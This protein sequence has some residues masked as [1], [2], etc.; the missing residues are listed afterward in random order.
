M[1]GFEPMTFLN[2]FYYFTIF[3]IYYNFYYCIISNE[4]FSL[5]LGL[6]PG[7]QL[8]IMSLMHTMLNSIDADMKSEIG[9]TR[10]GSKRSY[11]LKFHVEEAG[12]NAKLIQQGPIGVS[13]YCRHPISTSPVES[14]TARTMVPVL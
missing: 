4:T 8:P 6:N 11:P 2:H 7:L 9:S 14:I 5:I 12:A 13:Y 1:A 10:R 3:T